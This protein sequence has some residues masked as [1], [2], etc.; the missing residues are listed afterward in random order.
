[1]RIWWWRR[2]TPFQIWWWRGFL[3]KIAKNLVVALKIAISNLVV[4]RNFVNFATN[5]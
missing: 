2:K 3:R 1:M 5:F 4:E